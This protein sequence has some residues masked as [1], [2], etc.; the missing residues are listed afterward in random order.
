VP[1]RKHIDVFFAARFKTV[2][3]LIES[4]SEPRSLFS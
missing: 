2:L 1:F 4:S 3:H